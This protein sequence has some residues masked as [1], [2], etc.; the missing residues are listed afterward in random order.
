MSCSELIDSLRKAAD[1]R[2]RLLWQDAER[3]A[4]E[5]KAD[6]ARRIGQLHDDAGRR[7][8]SAQRD[9]IALARSAANSRAREIRL[10]SEQALSGR[11][12]D[13]A[14][15]LLS[16]LRDPGY[17]AVFTK[18]A[19]E[20]PALAWRLVRVNPEDALLAKKYFP[21]AE[22]V[23]DPGITGGVDASTE[24]GSVR[25]ISTFEKRLE[26]AWS[27]MLPILIR[28]VYREVADGVPAAS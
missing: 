5:A 16:G 27:D 15:P 23:S 24:G 9:A 22:I 13:A 21:G 17:E 18:I 19:R 25:I 2:V 6:V 14:G 20:L 1:E 4:A 7:Q 28:E 11:L 10:S 26:R 8:A 12:R 3:E